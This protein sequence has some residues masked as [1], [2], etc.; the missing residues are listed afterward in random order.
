MSTRAEIAQSLYTELV[1]FVREMAV[2]KEAIIAQTPGLSTAYSRLMNATLAE[3]SLAAHLGYLNWEGYFKGLLLEP[4]GK[5]GVV[6]D[7]EG[8]LFLSEVL[9][10]LTEVLAG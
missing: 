5:I 8:E 10:S 1:T 6:I 7:E 4:L 3:V 2:G 9:R